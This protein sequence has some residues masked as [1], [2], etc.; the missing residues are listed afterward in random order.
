MTFAVPNLIG[1]ITATWLAN[2]TPAFDVEWSCRN[3]E[4]TDGPKIVSNEFRGKIEVDCSFK[5]VSGGGFVQLKKHLL[6]KAVHDALAIHSGPTQETFEGMPSTGFDLT[7]VLEADGLKVEA[8]GLAHIATDETNRL[9]TAF[10]S[11]QIHGEGEAAYLRKLDTAANIRKDRA[12]GYSVHTSSF[13]KV[14]KPKLVPA[15][16]FLKKLSKKIEEGIPSQEKA[17]IEEVAQNL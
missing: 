8:R 10:S 11:T 12:D 14:E 2:Q 5:A 4:W 3:P 9:V 1:L 17:M 15:G 13:M 6:E 16:I 7:N